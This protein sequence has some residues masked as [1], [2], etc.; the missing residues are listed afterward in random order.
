[1]LTQV[2]NAVRQRQ[3]INPKTVLGFYATI[4]GLLFAGTVSCV[5]VLASSGTDTFLIP[6]LVVFCAIVLVL[7]LSGVFIITL[8]DP[9]KLMLT[10][11]SGADYL[12][13]Q[14]RT[15]VGDSLSGERFM[16]L[17]PSEERLTPMDPI[18]AEL[19][20][21]PEQTRLPRQSPEPST[22]EEGERS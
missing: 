12:A 4:L 7:L 14:Q 6:W 17:A 15:V 9:S 11:V 10:Q 2:T 22:S 3:A 1:M 21:A 18:D 16:T 19:V 5:A 13:I 8:I 20:N